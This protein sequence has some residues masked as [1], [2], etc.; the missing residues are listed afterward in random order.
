MK[1]P[2]FKNKLSKLFVG[3]SLLFVGLITANAQLLS[4]HTLTNGV[5]LINANPLLA[6]RMQFNNANAAAVTVRLYDNDSATSTNTVKGAYVTYTW[7][8]ATNTTVFTNVFENLQTNSH[9]YLS[10][11][12]TTNAAVTN[13]ATLVYPTITV[14]AAG[15]VTVDFDD[16]P[17]AVGRGLNAL[18]ASSNITAFL[19]Y[20]RL[21]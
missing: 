15:S 20:L 4:T 13:E 9:R 3:L 16:R 1:S 8:L 7:T 14:P 12:A 18:V 17:I 21:P 19:T 11:V 2:S 5:N 6:F 10:L